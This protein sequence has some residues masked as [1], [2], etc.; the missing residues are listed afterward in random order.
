MKP[1]NKGSEWCIWD[2]HIHTPASHH[3]NGGKRFAQMNAEEEQ[4]S[5]KSIIEQMNK[6]EAVAFSFMDYFTFDGYLK[7]KS[8]LDSQNEISLKK[9]LFPGMELRVEA[10]TDYKLN[11]HVIFN[12]N[13]TKQELSDFKS[14]LK[15]LAKNGRS[16]SDEA[17]I[18]AART[19]GEDKAKNYIGDKDY[20]SN[21]EVAFELGCKTIKVTR[22][23]LINAVAKLGKDKCLLILPYDTSDGILKLNWSDHPHDDSYFLMKADIVEA[24]NKD[25]IDLFLGRKNEKNQQYFDN[26][27]KAIGGE[28]KLVV[29]G[30][31]A[32]RIEDY[33]IFPGNKKTWLKAEPTFRGLR[34]A[35]V[36]P[37]SRCFVGE[38]PSKLKVV[39]SK[40]T[41]FVSKVSVKKESDSKLDEDW[42]D[43]VVNFNPELVAIIGNKGSGK[44]ALGDIVGLLGNSRQYDSFS[45]LN[46]KKFREKQGVKA[47]NFTSSL[48]WVSHDS[49]QKNLGEKI[50]I[51][52]VE[53]IK[54]IPQS[55]LEKLC[56]EISPKES[57]FDKELKAVIFSHI[58]DDQRLGFDS[59]DK[60]LEF[61]TE[62]NN[63]ELASLRIKTSKLNEEILS[64]RKKLTEDYKKTINNQLASKQS[65]LQAMKDSKPVEVKKPVTDKNEDPK[66]KE[67][68][69]RVEKLQADEKNLVL[70]IASRK[71]DLDAKSKK[72]A[73]LEKL[74]TQVMI[75]SREIESKVTS[76]NEI[77][78]DLGMDSKTIISFKSDVSSI[79]NMTQETSAS[80]RV[81]QEELSI[82]NP[83]SLSKK[84]ADMKEEL[85]AIS[86]SVDEPSRQ[87]KKYLEDLATWETS[88]SNI[89]GD[90]TKPGTIGYLNSLLAEINNIP[91]HLSELEM[92]R[93]DVTKEIIGKLQELANIYRDYY[94][95]VQK[96]VETNPFGGDTFKMSF[97]VS[98]VN[99]GFKE[100]FFTLINR[101]KAGTFYGLEDS[102][103]KITKMLDAHDFN[104]KQSVIDFLNL[105]ITS[106]ENDCRADK[107]LPN[108]LENQA[109]GEPL[110]LLNFIFGL[111]YLEP[112]Y[113]L[114][115]NGK[116]LEQLSPGERGTLLLIFYLMVDKD[117]RP[118][119]ID[120]PEE[121]LDNHT[122]FKVLVPCI[123]AAKKLRQIFLITHNPN[124]AVVCDAEQVIVA[125]IDKANKN[126][127]TYVSGG[128]EDPII[129]KSIIDILEGT[130]PA[131]NNRDYKYY[132]M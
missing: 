112:K 119:V 11:I 62:E 107:K 53:T 129:N 20:M 74:K 2:L 86:D 101:N 95:P 29:S 40:S 21:D 31:D 54:Y 39:N 50:D 84:L 87:Y 43:N 70:E 60:L 79:D 76:I 73:R 92:K 77:C 71:T 93:K 1:N 52:Q 116:N 104:S 64:C 115:L 44:S 38:M 89:Q 132:G 37:E 12:P 27:L 7:V 18:E 17:I 55:Y 106:L 63:A 94:A 15:L 114:Q 33:C 32:H 118:L 78:E 26:F 56:N 13:I 108:K 102:E 30:S 125:N 46:D 58:S 103:E 48:Y 42:F 90:E 5:C 83:K 6:T 127:V 98:I 75:L 124:L 80:I 35:M 45:F 128:I 41:K 96:F 36:E 19:L 23:S 34:Q 69:E 72:I 51:T 105:V 110:E 85:S 67:L 59:L 25:N 97:D 24:R 117:D 66:L 16:L 8:F 121:N 81:I 126:K 82:D 3:W 99:I 28:P 113:S 100:K 4:A 111:Q 122:I 14:D 61:K 109:K 130:R 120:Q 57:L 123:K 65:E 47:N 88:M 9:V 22:E 68:S 91:T 131:F 49:V 10:P